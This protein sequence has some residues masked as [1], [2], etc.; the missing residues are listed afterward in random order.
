MK[1]SQAAEVRFAKFLKLTQQV[2]RD[3]HD[4]VTRREE[5]EERL[6]RYQNFVRENLRRILTM[7]EKDLS[8]DARYE[9]LCILLEGPPT[10]GP[11][12]DLF[13]KRKVTQSEKPPSLP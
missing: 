5:A 2:V 4:S 10:P 13:L 9:L 8:S 7:P 11:E 12:L 6:W 1:I 3:C